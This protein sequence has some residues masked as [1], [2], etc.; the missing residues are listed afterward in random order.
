[1]FAS[2]LTKRSLATLIKGQDAAK[3]IMSQVS[4]DLELLQKAGV[5]PKVV[6]VVVGNVAESRIYLDRKRAA[7]LKAG[8]EFEEK[9]IPD[10]VDMPTMLKTIQDLNADP[11]VHGI[12]V[13]FPLTGSLPQCRV[14]EV[15]ALGVQSTTGVLRTSSV[16]PS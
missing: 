13:Q 4:Q 15:V 12:I 9:I 16:W 6:P 11:S 8:L 14:G 7:A 5:K 3:K 2:L 10:T 1:M